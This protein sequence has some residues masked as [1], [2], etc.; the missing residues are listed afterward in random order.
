MSRCPFDSFPGRIFDG[1]MMSMKHPTFF[2]N[3]AMH[4]VCPRSLLRSD[5]SASIFLDH[6]SNHLAACTALIVFALGTSTF[7]IDR[8]FDETSDRTFSMYLTVP[9]TSTLLFDWCQYSSAFG[10]HADKVDENAD[11]R[12][13]LNK[14]S[15]GV[16]ILAD[17]DS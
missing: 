10:M 9:Y 17:C 3:H 16:S 5:R 12:G 4:H 11:C 8:H 15:C 13:E 6:Q 1:F 7:Y 2:P 14:I